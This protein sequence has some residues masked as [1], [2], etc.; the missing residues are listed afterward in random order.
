VTVADASVVV[1][2]LVVDTDLGARARDAL[3]GRPSAP[4]LLDL[5]VGSALRRLAEDGRLTAPR[6]TAALQDLYDLPIARVSHRP[7]LARCW[8]LRG[9]VTFYDAAYV[10][11]AELLATPLLTTD[12]RLARA[13]GPRCEVR[14]VV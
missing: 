2:A 14:L 8:E 9:S 5:E 13:A 12:A 11:L 3:A 7:L 10:A 6:A 1:A 4:E